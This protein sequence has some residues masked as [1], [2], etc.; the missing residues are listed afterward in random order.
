MQGSRWQIC[1]HAV[2]ARAGTRANICQQMFTYRCSEIDGCESA[3]PPLF[4]FPS[5]SVCMSPSA[6]WAILH[7]H[8]QSPARCSEGTGGSIWWPRNSLPCHTA[9][10]NYKQRTGVY[11]CA[12]VW[13]GAGLRAYNL[14]CHCSEVLLGLI[15]HF[16]CVA[17]FKRR[18]LTPAFWAGMSKA[19]RDLTRVMFKGGGWIDARLGKRCEV[20]A[21]AVNHKLFSDSLQTKKK[22]G[23]S[24]RPQSRRWG[25]ET[26][27][28]KSKTK[29]NKK[30]ELPQMYVNILRC[31]LEQVATRAKRNHTA[32]SS[33]QSGLTPLSLQD[34]IFHQLNYSTTGLIPSSLCLISPPWAKAII[35]SFIKL[36]N[37]PSHCLRA[38]A[39]ER[40]GAVGR[41]GEPP[42]LF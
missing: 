9:G 12:C 18:Q 29:L 4:A 35:C 22:G 26:A 25:E 17:Q 10:P 15:S 7:L 21:R 23:S 6:T 24:H 1:I 42:L 5:L 8:C 41:E 33:L 38:H 32:L 14:T 19:H 3:R 37:I 34:P 40:H 20:K 39:R 28:R 13:A 2:G 16:L 31:S 11:M 27:V 30:I 36:D